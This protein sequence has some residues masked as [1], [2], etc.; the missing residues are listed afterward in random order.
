[1]LIGERAAAAWLVAP[2]ALSASKQA[3]VAGPA[4]AGEF[5]RQRCALQPRFLAERVEGKREQ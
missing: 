1:M 5:G 4:G 2:I 3:T